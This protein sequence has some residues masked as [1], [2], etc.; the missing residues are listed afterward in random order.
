MP[1][2]DWIPI[3]RKRRPPEQEKKPPQTASLV[4][5][6]LTEGLRALIESRRELQRQAQ[7]LRGPLYEL[8]RAM[9]RVG[10]QL[11][12]ASDEG[13]VRDLMAL[14]NDGAA[15]LTR[16]DSLLKRLDRDRVTIVV[17]G[18]LRQGKSRFLQELTGLTSDVIPTSDKGACTGTTL[19]VKSGP[20][21]SDARVVYW[22][23]RELLEEVI[24]P[25]FEE[26]EVDPPSGIDD[27]LSKRLPEKESTDRKSRVLDHLRSIQTAVAKPEWRALLGRTERVGVRDIVRYT[28][29]DV[30]QGRHHLVR[31]VELSARVPFCEEPLLEVVDL[32]GIGDL[33]PDLAVRMLRAVMERADLVLVI[34]MPQHTGDDWDEIDSRV[35][36]TL[37]K[38]FQNQ[39]G[40]TDGAALLPEPVALV[41]NIL[42]DRQNS[43]LVQHFEKAGRERFA[44]VH[45]VVCADRRA[46]R[47]FVADM[48]RIATREGLDPTFAR[49]VVSAAQQLAD[50]VVRWAEDALPRVRADVEGSRTRD[51][52]EGLLTTLNKCMYSLARQWH[53]E[54][55]D[56]HTKAK[57]LVDSVQ[58][59]YE[60]TADVCEG[61]LV[62]SAEELWERFIRHRG[63]PAA[64]QEAMN[65]VRPRLGAALRKSLER[66]LRASFSEA[67]RALVRTIVTDGPLGGLVN[68]N[69][70]APEQALEDLAARFR[71]A[72]ADTLADALQEFAHKEVSIGWELY[73]MARQQMV[74]LDAMVPSTAKRLASFVEEG[75]TNSQGQLAHEALVS[76]ALQALR[77]IRW[78][79]LKSCEDGELHWL[80]YSAI[81]DLWDSLCFGPDAERGLMRV[82]NYYYEELS[83]D[84]SG[85]RAI[86]LIS[87]LREKA[88]RLVDRLS[89]E[90]WALAR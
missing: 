13:L 50:K 29:M 89:P 37:L 45:N 57:S 40:N 81:D 85:R 25:C 17:V 87:E 22:D 77:L 31:E 68:S 2:F 55:Q 61:D 48:L 1:L 41:I 64:L 47:Q 32:P 82:V 34:R 88:S 90:L 21:G 62:P 3:P 18:R 11:G 5:P 4:E 58:K 8:V 14:H 28:A 15:L 78:R 43:H 42:D 71:Q 7:E 63:W 86:P 74:L 38:A 59:V 10:E 24:K 33:R 30:S 26:L 72:G 23:E 6:G 84:P 69:D 73:H 65:T 36:D 44:S 52:Y 49:S 35:A 80:L 9:E 16:C 27:F 19:C 79:L 66:E 76:E 39:F 51:L 83:G 53:P 75:D 67:K 46:V 20:S 12:Q 70:S 56:S 54:A 60:R